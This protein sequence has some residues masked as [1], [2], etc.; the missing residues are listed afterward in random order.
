MTRNIFENFDIDMDWTRNELTRLTGEMSIAI[1]TDN[2]EPHGSGW[3]SQSEM[4]NQELGAKV[5]YSIMLKLA[6]HNMKQPSQSD[7]HYNKY[8][9][10]YMT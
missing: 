4:E 7:M 6:S 3:C 1:V 2:N 10:I 9:K 8:G 5:R